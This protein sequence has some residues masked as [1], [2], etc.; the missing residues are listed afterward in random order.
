[1]RSAYRVQWKGTPNPYLGVRKAFQKVT[2][3]LRRPE[4]WVRNSTETWRQEARDWHLGEMTFW[5][6][7]R[8]WEEK[9]KNIGLERTSGT[10]SQLLVPCLEFD[11]GSISVCS[12]SKWICPFYGRNKWS[13]ERSQFVGSRAGTEPR[14]PIP[15]IAIPLQR[16]LF[17]SEHFGKSKV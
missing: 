6:E 2:S 16:Q 13:Q 7:Q 4:G 17:E 8:A 14:T 15:G 11:H 12:C 10:R 5:M 3:N 1:M 9:L